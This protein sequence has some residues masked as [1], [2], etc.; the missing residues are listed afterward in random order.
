VGRWGGGGGNG[1]SFCGKKEKKPA[2]VFLADLHSRR[3]AARA[4]RATALS[5]AHTG[6]R[7]RTLSLPLTATSNKWIESSTP[8]VATYGAAAATHLT[9]PLWTGR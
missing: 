2:L 4:P 8:P 5:Q 9:G 7:S 3:T 1:F 6:N